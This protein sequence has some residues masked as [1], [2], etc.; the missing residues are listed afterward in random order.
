MPLA[1]N[2]AAPTRRR[3]SGGRGGSAQHE[4]RVDPARG[5]ARPSR[6]GGSAPGGERRQSEGGRSTY[7]WPVSIPDLAALRETG[8]AQ[9][10]HWPDGEA[11]DATVARL[12][13]VP[14]LVFAG[15]CDDLKGKLA[16][17]ARGEAF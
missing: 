14:P 12:R 11:L 15:E 10:P 5:A 17:V 3:R 9:Q 16:A 13:K 6:R 4:G 8:A 2:S 7:A 1:K